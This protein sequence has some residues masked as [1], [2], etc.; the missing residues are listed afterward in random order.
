LNVGAPSAAHGQRRAPHRERPWRSDLSAPLADNIASAE[1]I[2]D[3]VLMF[4]TPDVEAARRG[5]AQLGTRFP[6]FAIAPPGDGCEQRW[7]L[8]GPHAWLCERHARLATW[9]PHEG[10]DQAEFANGL[11]YRYYSVGADGTLGYNSLSLAEEGIPDSQLEPRFSVAIQR[12]Q[13]K[14][15]STEWYALTSHWLWLPL[16]DLR[17]ATASL[18]QGESLVGRSTALG[19]VVVDD[20]RVF[21]H[22]QGR[23]TGQKLPRLQ[24]VTVRQ[25]Q[26]PSGAR[27]GE[28]WLELDGGG[29]LRSGAV[30]WLTPRTRPAAVT[31][32]ERW[33]YVNTKQQTLTAYEGDTPVFATLVSTGIGAQGSEQATPPGLHRIWV[34]LRSTDMTNLEA[35]RAERYYAIEDVPWVMFFK[36]AYALHGAFWHA[37]FGSRRSHGCVNL[38]PLDAQFLFHWVSPRVPRGWHAAHPTPYDPG[39]PILVE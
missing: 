37:S 31:A 3:D 15:G 27:R 5:S 18:F 11:P 10:A 39:T 25:L 2:R 38:S 36:G 24:V 6:I 32:N 9:Q 1:V 34:K 14:P 12:T 8:V 30:R 7:L 35:E 20:A 28:G 4:R 23:L 13:Q 21:D 22:P 26:L 33:L 17:P 19:W 29:W 16:R